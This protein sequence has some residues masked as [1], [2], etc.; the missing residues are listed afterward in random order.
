MPL[1]RT[2]CM[3]VEKLTSI[4]AAVE[5]FEPGVAVLGISPI[6]PLDARRE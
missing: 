2:G 1:V 3:K 6:A 5:G 4:L